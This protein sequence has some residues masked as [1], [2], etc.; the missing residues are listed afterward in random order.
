M[1][2]KWSLMT[3]MVAVA[4]VLLGNWGLASAGP[5]LPPVPTVPPGGGGGG[6]GSRN[7]GNGYASSGHDDVRGW[8]SVNGNG[9]LVSEISGSVDLYPDDN[10]N[11]GVIGRFSASIYMHGSFAEDPGEFPT[12]NQGPSVNGRLSIDEYSFVDADPWPYVG[13]RPVFSLSYDAN[14][15]YNYWVRQP[16]GEKELWTNAFANFYVIGGRVTNSSASFNQNYWSPSSPPA[17]EWFTLN[18]WD[19]HISVSGVI[20]P[21]PATLSLLGVGMAAML[22]RRRREPKFEPA[23]S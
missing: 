20:V 1:K 19:G 18:G 17:P 11:D 21:E 23:V 14:T 15:N 2:A 16:G 4:L 13:G 5:V 7:I 9:L 8:G 10:P 22:I 6:G 12:D 3:V